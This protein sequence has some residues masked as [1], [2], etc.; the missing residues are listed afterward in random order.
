MRRMRG[1]HLAV[2]TI[3]ATAFAGLLMAPGASAS[4]I[5]HYQAG[6]FNVRDLFLPAHGVHALLYN[7]FYGTNRLNDANGEQVDEVVIHPPPGPSPGFPTALAVDVSAYVAAPTMI[8]VKDLKRDG[9]RIGASIT[10]LFPNTNLDAA[11]AKSNDRSGDVSGGSFGIGDLFVRPLWL[12][13]TSAR[14]ELG[15]SY[16]FYAPIGEYQTQSFRL[17]VGQP[18]RIESP[19]NLGHGFWT[20]QFQGVLGWYPK[21]EHAT[22]LMSAATY[23]LNGKKDGFDVTPGA[24]L[25]LNWGAS[26]VLPGRNGESL[27]YELG[28]AG[29]DT[30]Q[31]TDDTGA[32]ARSGRAQVHAVGW[33]VGFTHVATAFQVNLHAFYEYSALNRFQ[34]TAYDVS[35][36]VRR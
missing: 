18:I 24:N 34:G 21:P 8:V 32:D 13:S 9:L 29:F 10:Q 22:A 11:F 17:P 4:G 5:G 23:E 3:A 25:S 26:Q 27:R 30:W 7:H 33:Q 1:Q 19:D 35:L 28:V 6:L 20:H 31:V 16:G 36:G 15:A 12:G 2:R 14:W